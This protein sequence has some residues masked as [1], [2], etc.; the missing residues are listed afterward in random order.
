MCARYHLPEDWMELDI[1]W[2]SHLQ[3]VYASAKRPVDDEVRPTN[4]APIIRLDEHG[5][6]RVELRQWGFIRVWPGKTGKPVKR[7]LINAVGEEL[8]YKRSFKAA[9]KTSRCLVPMAAWVEWPTY[10]GTK[11]KVRIGLKD[12]P[13]FACAGLYE[14]SPNPA[15]GDPIETFTVVTVPPLAFL[16]QVHDRAPLVLQSQDY[17]AWLE[18]GP[19]AQS[20]IGPYL[21]G[22]DAFW[23]QRLEPAKIQN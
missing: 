11:Y 13:A 20:L 5:D 8:D 3:D 17:E 16:G 19:P 1:Q 21:G 4:I 23:I 10:D 2:W 6:K 7:S 9:W 22:D 14:S 18:G 12:R 15:G